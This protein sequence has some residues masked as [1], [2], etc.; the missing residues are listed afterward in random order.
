MAAEYFFLF[1]HVVL[2]KATTVQPD[3]K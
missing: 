3:Y 2:S 1:F